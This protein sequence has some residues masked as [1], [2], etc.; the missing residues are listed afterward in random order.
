MEQVVEVD[1]PFLQVEINGVFL[2]FRDRRQVE[3]GAFFQGVGEL[4]MKIGGKQGVGQKKAQDQPQ[5]QPGLELFEMVRIWLQVGLAVGR[6]ID[7]LG[8]STFVGRYVIK[9]M[10]S[11]PDSL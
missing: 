9:Q 10:T 1:D 7:M 8:G 4:E 2:A 6:I 3:L 11:I 5:D